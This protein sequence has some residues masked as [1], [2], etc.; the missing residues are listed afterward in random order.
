MNYINEFYETSSK[1]FWNPSDGPIGRDVQVLPLIEGDGTLLEYGF[2]SGS[3]L[4]QVAKNHKFSK[5]IG[6]DISDAVIEKAKSNIQNIN[7]DY[8]QKLKFIKPDQAGEKIPDIKSNSVDCVVSVATIEHVLN[9]CAFLAEIGALLKPGGVLII[10]TP[11]RNDVLLK[12]LPEE[13]PEFYYRTVHRWYFDR[14]S[15]RQCVE[16]AGLDVVSERYVQTY[17]MANVLLWLKD[18]KP[19]GNSRMPGIDHVADQLWNGYLQATGQSDNIYVYARK[20][21]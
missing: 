20:P 14:K 8:C 12:L 11:N 3:L 10:A 16:L 6:V 5:V 7:K 17:G 13:F 19:N 18:R 2:G 9:P 15:L 1:R 21:G 4:F